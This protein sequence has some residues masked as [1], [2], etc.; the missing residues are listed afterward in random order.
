MSQVAVLFDFDGTLADTEV[1]AMEV[2]YWQLA[3]YK[4]GVEAKGKGAYALTP[5][6]RDKWIE[7]NAGQAFELLLA[8]VRQLVGLGSK[9]WRGLL[10][11]SGAMA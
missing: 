3:P 6:A 7:E 5:E 2:S 4:P 8:K 9:P 1:T 11:S 10:D